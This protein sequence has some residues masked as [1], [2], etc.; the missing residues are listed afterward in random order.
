MKTVKQKLN[1]IKQELAQEE[2]DINYDNEDEYFDEDE[3]FD[4][5]EYS[6]EDD[7]EGYGAVYCTKEVQ[8]AKKKKKTLG[9][10]TRWL[11]FYEN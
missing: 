5:D 8:Y 6:D 9:S 2:L 1:E 11:L 4:E 10:H 3:D 7:L